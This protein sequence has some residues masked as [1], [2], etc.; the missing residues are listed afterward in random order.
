MN[1]D[2]G[3]IKR[4]LMINQIDTHYLQCAHLMSWFDS[5]VDGVSW[6]YIDALAAYFV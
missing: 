6:A 3:N 1:S 5:V 4:I 2:A